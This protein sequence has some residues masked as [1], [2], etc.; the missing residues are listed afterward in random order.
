MKNRAL[1]L[2]ASLLAA[3]GLAAAGFAAGFLSAQSSQAPPP[4]PEIVE[5]PSQNCFL[6]PEMDGMPNWNDSQL[7]ACQVA[8]MSLSAGERFAAN[9]AVTVRIA[10]QDGEYFALTED[11]SAD[12]INLYVHAGVIIRADAW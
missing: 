10:Y 5:L 11:F 12:R 4:P 3:A 6:G 8:G 7:V 2:I 9:A 1:V